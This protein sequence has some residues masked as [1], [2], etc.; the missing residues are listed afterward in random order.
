[1]KIDNSYAFYQD[2]PKLHQYPQN[3]NKN[4]SNNLCL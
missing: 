1:M 2:A 3:Q 4:P